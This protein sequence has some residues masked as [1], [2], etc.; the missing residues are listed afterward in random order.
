[1]KPLIS[2]IIPNYNGEATLDA[3]LAAVTSLKDHHY[4]LI[5]VD[6][7]SDDHSVA[8]IKRYRCKLVESAEHLGAAHARNIGAQYA[9]GEYIFFTDADC[10]M[11]QKTLTQIRASLSQSCSRAIIGGT[12]SVQPY[13][14]SFFSRFQSV[15]I[16]YF[17][18]KHRH[19]ADYIASHAMLIKT[20]LFRSSGGFDE[21]QWP[22]L[23][24]VEFSH[25]CRSAG[26]A[27][28]MQPAIQ[29]QHIFNYSLLDSCRN[30]MRKTR[31]WVQYSLKNQ[32]LLADSGTASVELKFNVCI[33]FSCLLLLLL[34]GLTH[35]YALLLV[36]VI[37]LCGVNVYLN[38]RLLKAFYDAGGVIFALAASA[39]YLLC[40]PLPVALGAFAGFSDSLLNIERKPGYS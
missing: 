25:R 2:I 16:N 3:C 18:T 37:S 15:F 10:I 20:E 5:V 38:A 27:L 32:D 34:Y 4:E 24:D 39:Y 35:D 8:I 22:I 13:D 26:T 23:E 12:Y 30:A 1:M 29:V 33:F 17:E 19:R 40:Y 28:V 36:I 7:G 14:R 9:R 6:D 31:Y 11:Q 21:E